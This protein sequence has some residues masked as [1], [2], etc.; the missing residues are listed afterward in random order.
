MPGTFLSG[1]QRALVLLFLTL[2]AAPARSAD[3]PSLPNT[4][5]LTL[6]GDIASRLVDGVDKFLLREID[7][8]VERRARY[9]RRDFSSPE[10]YNKSI[11]S[12]RKR[13]SG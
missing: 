8:S 6:D 11:E 3:G 1:L 5:P 9:W 7:K 10:A 13:Y 12:N 4:Q 2:V